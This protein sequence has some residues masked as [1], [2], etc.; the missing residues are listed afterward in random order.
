MVSYGFLWF[1]MVSLR[2]SLL[3]MGMVL[4]FNADNRFALPLVSPGENGEDST[5]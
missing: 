2:C 5:G 3:I 1:P 4:G